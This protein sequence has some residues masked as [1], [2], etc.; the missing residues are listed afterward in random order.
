MKREVK[1]RQVK[2]KNGG[3]EERRKSIWKS[4]K[5]ATGVLRDVVSRGQGV[6]GALELEVSHLVK[7]EPATT[8]AAT[9][10]REHGHPHKEEDGEHLE[11]LCVSPAHRL[12]SS[13]KKLGNDTA[14]MPKPA[15]QA[16]RC[17]EDAYCTLASRANGVWNFIR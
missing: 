1:E 11:E 16:R 10:V 2:R 9:E 17:I 8:T 4:E 7:G 13:R 6:R 15:A 14:P 5:N 12:W 3:K